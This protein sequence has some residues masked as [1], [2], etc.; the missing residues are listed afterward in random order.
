MTDEYYSGDGYR[1][2]I[3]LGGVITLNR[4]DGSVLQDC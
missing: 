1:L 2:E 4:P 3:Q